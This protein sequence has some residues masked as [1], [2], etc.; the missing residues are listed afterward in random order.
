[1]FLTGPLLTVLCTHFNS[2]CVLKAH[3]FL[4]FISMSC[5]LPPNISCHGVLST[6]FFVLDKPPCKFYSVLSSS[7]HLASIVLYSYSVSVLLSLYHSSVVMSRQRKPSPA[8]LCPSA[9]A[10]PIPLCGQLTRLFQSPLLLPLLRAPS[11]TQTFHIFFP[12]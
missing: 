6:I 11:K 8:H 7:R 3:A 10:R 4:V 5:S 12:I 1:M 2:F 9:R